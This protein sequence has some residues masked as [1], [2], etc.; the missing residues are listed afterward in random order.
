MAAS[1]RWAASSSPTPTRAPWAR[2]AAVSA[3]SP[4]ITASDTVQHLPLAHADDVLVHLERHPERLLEVGILA[5]RKQRLGPHDRLADARQLVEIALLAQA[6]DGV[7]DARGNR[8]RNARDPRL[9]DLALAPRI[10]VVD[11]VIQAAALERIVEL[12]R[13]IRRQQHDGPCHRADRAQLGN[14]HREV[15]QELEQKRLELVIGAVDLVDQEHDLL[16]R[17]GLDG[18]EQRPPEQEASGEQFA[19]VDAALG[20][21]QGEE[22]TSVIPVV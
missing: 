5:E 1:A 10:G 15:R 3:L 6:R 22:L 9:D 11:P 19:L 17:A 16:L 14:R 20:G 12:A 8:L 18:I 7:D 4:P 13:A 2:S 21:P